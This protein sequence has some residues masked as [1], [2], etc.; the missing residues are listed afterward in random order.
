M[1]KL[2]IATITLLAFNVN[3]SFAYKLSKPMIESTPGFHFTVEQGP[4]TVKRVSKR[5][6][7]IKKTSKVPR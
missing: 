4:I 7:T 5:H 3:S 1:K 2:T 6:P